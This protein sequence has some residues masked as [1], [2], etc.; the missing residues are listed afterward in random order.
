MV[1]LT[2]CV[3]FIA[4]FASCSRGS[5]EVATKWVFTD[6]KNSK[7]AVIGCS[8]APGKL[9]QKADAEA[10]PSN[11][12]EDGSGTPVIAIAI[13][14]FLGRTGIEKVVIPESVTTIGTFAFKGCTGLKEV[15]LPEGLTSIG[16]YAFDG[17]EKLGS[18]S[19]DAS[20]DEL[21]IVFPESLTAIGTYAFRNCKKLQKIVLH[22]NLNTFDGAFYNCTGLTGVTLEE[23]IEVIGEG[24]FKGCTGIQNITFPNS[25]VKIEAF[26]FK[27]CTKLKSVTIPENVVVV[28][29]GAFENCKGLSTAIFATNKVITLE[30]TFR[31][32][33]ALTNV[34]LPAN[35]Q[36]IGNYTFDY[37]TNLSEIDI[38]NTL[39][40][41]GRGAFGNC[42]AFT[43]IDYKGSWEDWGAIIKP[44][45]SN[46]DKTDTNKV[47]A[48]NKGT[49]A[50]TV[51]TTDKPR[52]SPNP[53]TVKGAK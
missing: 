15:V 49:D 34:T 4:L 44:D 35:I 13:A 14:A 40:S 38:N 32:C 47:D 25:L 27:D 39:L 5:G 43:E 24:A 42:D 21:S 19:E 48:W 2:L 9:F 37:C 7:G 31:N 50:I 8:V 17:C 23:G 52:N 22:N 20:V 45:T 53:H 1:V 46:N 51:Y 11:S 18:K 36:T 28:G 16:N 33:S 41:L 26:A 29:K 6:I 30:Q 10:I 12:K 3:P